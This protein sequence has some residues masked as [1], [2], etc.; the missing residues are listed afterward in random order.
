MCHTMKLTLLS[1]N[2]LE[3]LVLE[4]NLFETWKINIVNIRAKLNNIEVLKVNI[5]AT[6]YIL[7]I[8]SA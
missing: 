7:N 2:S 6:Y 4:L 3:I 5:Q 8:S 1:S